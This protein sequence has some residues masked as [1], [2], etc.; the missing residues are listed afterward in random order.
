M[1]LEDIYFVSQT[2]AAV[3]IV[4]SLIYAALQFRVYA[5]AAHEVRFA[6]SV[7]HIQQFR[8]LIASNPEVARIYRDGL[9][10]LNKLD[11]LDQWRFGALMQEVLTYHA[12]EQEFGDV[13]D[14]ATNLS[15]L[16]WVLGRPGARQWW[17][18]AQRAFPPKIRAIAEKAVSSEPS[19]LDDMADR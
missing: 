1:S 8:L 9:E 7:S 5:K 16:G 14:S 4:A 10:D 11:A 12:L 17:Q 13:T 6:Q 19:T 15:T 2:I 18:K 3:A